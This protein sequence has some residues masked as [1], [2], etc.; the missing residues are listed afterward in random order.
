MTLRRGIALAGTAIL[1]A[2]L[3]ACGGPA[4][5]EPDNH[6]QSTHSAALSAN[7]IASV[8]ASSYE[9]GN[10]PQNAIDQ[11]MATRW[12]AQ[13][14]GQ[15]IV[16]DLG[17]VQDIDAMS[18]AWYSG[19]S[20]QNSFVILTSADGTSYATAYSGTSSGTTANLELYPFAATSARYVKVVVNG[21]TVNDW[22]SIS[23]LA[24]RQSAPP[25]GIA[26]VSASSYETGNPPQNAIDL[27][28]ATR[29]SALGKGQYI[30]ADLGQLKAIDAVNIAWYSGASRK[31][32]FVILTSADGTS[33][34]TAYSGTSSGTTASPEAYAI[35]VISTRYVKVVTNGNSVN[36][37]A[38]I[39]ELVVHAAAGTP[40]PAPGPVPTVSVAVSPATTSLQ[41]SQTV[42]FTATVS[43]TSNTTVTWSVQEGTAGGTVTSTGAYTAPSAAGTYHVVAKSQADTTKTASATVTV[44]APLP[45]AVAITPSSTSIAAGATVAF[46]ATVSNSS[47]QGVTWSVQE[48]SAGGSVTSAGSYTAPSTAG[49]YHVVA[50]SQADTSKTASATVTVAAAPPPPPPP[51]APS[52][53]SCAA[54]PL[55]TTGAKY[56]VCSCDAGAAAGC[57]AG[58]DANSGTSPS[59]PWKTI[60]KAHGVAASPPSPWRAAPICSGSRARTGCASSTS[61]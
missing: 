33:Y 59:A 15:Y 34:A 9:T 55:R 58:N 39:S 40:D 60:G 23:E 18:I 57:V 27:N 54:E 50:T 36:D 7:G 26:S 10:L 8:S 49:T 53:G 29:W 17:Q 25:S 20:R 61:R 13:G 1:A 56:Y 4:D 32:S 51:P 35:S 11:N 22:A 21:N 31:N 3:L 14:K 6:S 12:S 52:S 24:V 46:S 41:T 28:M 47:N 44:T 30:I 19:A 48:G 2:G 16:A 37:W 45:V 38:S 5:S 42:G 43:G